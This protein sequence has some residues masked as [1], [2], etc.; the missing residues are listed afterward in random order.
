MEKG[1]KPNVINIYNQWH[2]I[3]GQLF[4]FFVVCKINVTTV[5]SKFHW[6]VTYL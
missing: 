4:S 1:V 3:G 2:T 5:V 6:E